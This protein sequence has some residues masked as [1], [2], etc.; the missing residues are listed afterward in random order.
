MKKT[1][2][3]K[4]VFADGVLDAAASR[5]AFNAELARLMDRE[6]YDWDSLAVEVSTVLLASPGLETISTKALTRRIWEARIESGALKGLEGKA[7]D[8]AYA[9]LDKMVPDY[10]AE[11]PDMFHIG[12]KSGVAVRYVLGEV[13]DN[14][15][16]VFRH[17]D[18]AW[19]KLTAPKPE[20]DSSADATA[21]AAQ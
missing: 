3:T 14:G 7:R 1:I 15:N 5:E 8:A 2:V 13:D 18:E 17:S 21:A 6:T 19:A 4:L 11:N 9:R 16:Q 20:K 10:I 12:R